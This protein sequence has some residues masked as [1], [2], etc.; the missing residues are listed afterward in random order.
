MMNYLALAGGIFAGL[1]A[2]Y[3]LTQLARVTVGHARFDTPAWAFTVNSVIVALF[4]TLA[5]WLFGMVA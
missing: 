5:A 1:I 2:L 4:G 3:S